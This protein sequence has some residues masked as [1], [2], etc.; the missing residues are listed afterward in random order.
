MATAPS[1][2]AWLGNVGVQVV[3]GAAAAYN[4]VQVVLKLVDGR[5]ADAFLSF[6]YAVV[7]GYVLFES[8]AVRR[9]QQAERAAEATEPTTD[10]A[11]PRD[12]PAD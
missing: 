4:V 2:P 1:R 11:D 5:G 10:P 9:A 6:A 3:A 7:F 12:R 8:L